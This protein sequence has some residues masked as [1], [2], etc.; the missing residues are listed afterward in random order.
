MIERP[1]GRRL[2][3]YR[4]LTP[5]QVRDVLGVS[6]SWVY[7]AAS[8]GR[9]PSIRLGGPTG[10]IRFVEADLIAHLERARAKWH[11]GR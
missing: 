11:R 7:R 3:D 8:D 1:S 10:P 2:D 9:L 4:L 5:V 6:R